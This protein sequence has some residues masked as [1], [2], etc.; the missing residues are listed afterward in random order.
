MAALRSGADHCPA[1]VFVTASG[2]KQTIELDGLLDKGFVTYTGLFAPLALWVAGYRHQIAA[3]IFLWIVGSSKLPT[4][5][6]WTYLLSNS[7][8]T[9][10]MMGWS[11]FAK[12]KLLEQ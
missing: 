9:L 11:L 1:R 2:Q 3:L 10:S 7:R 6:E 8:T 12:L 5:K 4:V